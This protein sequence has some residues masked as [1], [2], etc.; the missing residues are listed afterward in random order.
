MRSA[1]S[2][3]VIGLLAV[4]ALLCGTAAQAEPRPFS[5]Y[6]TAGWEAKVFLR[7]GVTGYKAV[8]DGRIQ[9]IESECDSSA[10]GLMW[11]DKINL[12]ATPIL[13]WRWKI[14]SVYEGLN[15]RIKVG[16]D[17]PV[18]VYAVRSG[19]AMWW[20]TRTIVYVW[21][22]GEGESVED[23]PDPYTDSAHVVPLRR[24]AAGAG[25]WQVQRRDLREDFKKYFDLDLKTLDAVALMTDCDDHH[26]KARAWYGDIRLLAK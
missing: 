14:D 19:G 23:W 5:L 8:N 3:S 15:E 2:S 9:V 11:R 20:K 17:Y 13:A 12:E 6:G 25:E 24:G 10:S 4:S 7:H 21:S 16:D 1:I 18:R 26:G 22:N